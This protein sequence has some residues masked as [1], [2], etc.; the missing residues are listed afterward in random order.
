MKICKKCSGNDQNQFRPKAG[1]VCLACEL[2][3]AR[4]YRQT[5]AYRAVKDR[6]VKS[7]K[8]VE[9]TRAREEK[10]DVKEKRRLASRSPQGRM[11]KQ[12]YEATPKGQATRKQAIEKYRLTEKGKTKAQER[13]RKRSKKPER[14]Q[15]QKTYHATYIQT[16]KGKLMLARRAA[17]R[18]EWVMDTEHPLTAKEWL[19]ILTANKYRCYY[20]KKKTKLTLDHVIPLSKGGKHTASNIVP[21][22]GPCN[23]Q[24]HDKILTLL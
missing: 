13:D 15:K 22:C 21:A 23:S 24:K 12:K 5:A 11:N 3:Q 10:L 19:S 4:L 16:I 6:Y 14:K 20:C 7:P 1:N 8:G 18:Y 2:E 17:R 9:T